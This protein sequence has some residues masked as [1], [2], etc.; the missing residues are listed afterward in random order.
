[1][2]VHALQRIADLKV[3]NVRTGGRIFV[4]MRVISLTGSRFP[5]DPAV[6]AVEVLL[7]TDG[8]PMNA[9]VEILQGPDTN[10]QAGPGNHAEETVSHTS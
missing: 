4:V 10:K 9:R 2:H 3:D 8:M 1:M 6:E 5:M 7:T